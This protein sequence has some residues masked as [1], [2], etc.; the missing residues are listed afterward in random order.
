MGGTQRYLTAID[1][2]LEDI[3]ALIA[4][5][6]IQSPGIGE[7]T[8][9]GF[10]NG[11]S[12]LGC[13]TIDKQKALIRTR[14]ANL[15]S[16]STR[17]ILKNVYKHS[18]KLVLT[19]PNQKTINKETAVELWQLFFSPPSILWRTAKHNWLA[20]W[21]EFLNQSSTKG[22]NA[23]VWEQTF[24]FVEEVLRDEKLGWWDEMASWPGI[25][26]EFVQWLGVHKGIGKTERQ[27]EEMEF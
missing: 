25:I 12:A 18:F 6:I 19:Q 26:D 15:A 14:R 27:F 13:E 5:E 16:P 3:S 2:S 4:Q 9:E 24:K 22:V 21:V 17:D 10:I 1:V 8:R 23:D 11:W 7:M 20:Y